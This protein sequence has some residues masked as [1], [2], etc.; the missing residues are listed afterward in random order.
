[1]SIAP[2]PQPIESVEATAPSRQEFESRVTTV[3]RSQRRCNADLFVIDTPGDMMVIKDFSKKSWRIRILGR[4]QI[5]HECRAYRWLGDMRGIPRFIGRIDRHA[6]A[7]E[8]VEVTQLTYA[9]NR[10]SAGTRHLE[11]LAAVLKEFRSRGFVH[12]DLRGRR[13]VMI[14]PGGEI[15]VLDLAGAV[16]FRPDG[17]WFRLLRPLI[18]A[19]DRNTLSKWKVLLTPDALTDHERAS[20]RRFRR[21]QRIWFFNRKGSYDE[22]WPM[23]FPRAVELRHPDSRAGS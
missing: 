1:M 18:E 22:K 17:F 5:A 12:L 23:T 9:A 11:G 6:L 19:N 4:M 8:K 14:R 20:L 16:W 15:V 21:L 2:Q 3:L 10:Y 13:N 7:I